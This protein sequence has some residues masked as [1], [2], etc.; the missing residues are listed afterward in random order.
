MTNYAVFPGKVESQLKTH[1]L[2]ENICVYADSF[3]SH[4][5]AIMVPIQNSL[6]KLAQEL[7]KA[8]MDY[9]SLCKDNEMIQ[10][11]IVLVEIAF[12]L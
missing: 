7:G 9:E 3:Q 11:P 5:V 4:T 1:P 12:Y 2:V 10:V 8:S 6:I